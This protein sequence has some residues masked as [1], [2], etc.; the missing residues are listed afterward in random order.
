[1]GETN[2]DKENGELIEIDEAVPGSDCETDYSD[3]DFDK[4]PDF[5]TEQPF[6]SEPIFFM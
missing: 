1:M 6:E 3:E 5:K 4:D 2:N